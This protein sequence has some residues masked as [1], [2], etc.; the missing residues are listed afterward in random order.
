MV[1]LDGVRMCGNNYFL[2][3]FFARKNI[4]IYIFLF[5]KIYF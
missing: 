2:K 3:Y 1:V 4:K 5:F